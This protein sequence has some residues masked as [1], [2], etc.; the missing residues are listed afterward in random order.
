MKTVHIL[1]A[2]LR[3]EIFNKTCQSWLDQASGETDIQF[4][5]LV[6]TQADKDKI[7]AVSSTSV[8]VHKSDRSGVA[9][10]SHI[11]SSNLWGLNPTDLIIFASDDFFPQYYWDILLEEQFEDFDGVLQINDKLGKQGKNIVSIP[12]MTY[13]ALCKLN[14]VIYHPAYTHA[15]SDNELHDNALELGILKDISISNPEIYIEHRHFSQGKRGKDTFDTEN[16]KSAPADAKLYQQRKKLPLIERLI[17]KKKEKYNVVSFSLWGNDPKY[18]AGAFKNVELAN[19]YYPGWVCRIYHDDTVPQGVLDK[20]IDA[21][22]ELIKCPTCV[23]RSGTYWRIRVMFDDRVDRFI[24]RD[25]DSRINAREA[26][27]VHEWLKSGWSFHTMRDHAYHNTPMM[28]GMWGGTTSDCKRFKLPYNAWVARTHGRHVSDQ[29]FL[30][31]VMW[32][33]ISG[34]ICSHGTRFDYTGDEKEFLVKLEEGLFVGQVYDQNDN[35]QF[36]Y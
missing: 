9:G 18:L 32:P 25:T 33:V 29:V 2:T 3:P 5:I 10:P 27:A 20:L 28:G 30:K 26:D 11:L 1:W 31:D 24:I 8:M 16:E 17:V 21:G 22:A 13:K 23:K 34:N 19:E 7:T 6:E 4:H 15:W 12:I 35:P 14:K 36:V